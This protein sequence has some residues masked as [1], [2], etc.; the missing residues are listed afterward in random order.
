LQVLLELTLIQDRLLR[1]LDV[2]QGWLEALNNG[3][4]P[5]DLTNSISSGTQST[6]SINKAMPQ[7]AGDPFVHGL[8]VLSQIESATPEDLSIAMS[9][10]VDDC[11]PK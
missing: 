7:M 8:Y 11:K 1:V 9:R 6:S 5:A 3:V 10:T 2:Q 4:S